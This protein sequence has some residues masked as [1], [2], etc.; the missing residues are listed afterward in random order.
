[1]LSI[2]P[3]IGYLPWLLFVLNFRYCGTVA[4]V[5]ITDDQFI[6][7]P[8][9]HGKYPVL[10]SND[11]FSDHVSLKTYKNY[12]GLIFASSSSKWR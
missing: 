12:V 5:M 10:S 9:Y 7:H 4:S 1:M 3:K 2:E 8:I 11:S 6:H